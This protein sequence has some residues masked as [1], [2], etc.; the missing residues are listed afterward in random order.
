MNKN[1]CLF[2]I[3]STGL[4]LFGACRRAQGPSLTAVFEG[5]PEQ[6]VYIDYVQAPDFTETYHDTLPLRQGELVWNRE[7]AQ[8]AEV[9]VVLE[10][11]ADAP[12]S[13][14]LCP[15]ESAKLKARWEND[16]W[17]CKLSGSRQLTEQSRLHAL[18]R[19][20]YRDM[21]QLRA[22]INKAMEKGVEYADEQLVDSL[23]ALY[24]EAQGVFSDV[25]M[26]YV[27]AYPEDVRS[28][29]YLMRHPVKDT[30]L[31]YY[32]TL[33]EEVREGFLKEKLE[34]FRLNAERMR[35]LNVNARLT[36]IGA[37]APDFEMTDVDGRSFRLSDY[38][39]KYVVLDFWGT[40]CP[41][42]VKGMPKMKAYHKKY[43]RKVEFIGISNRDKAEKLKDFLQKENIGWRNAQ[44]A[45]AEN[46]DVVLMYGVTGYPTKVL[47]A[48]GLVVKG[49]YLGEVEEF[50][51][52]LDAIK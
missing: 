48:P 26:E 42:C 2:G 49:R 10:R 47:L 21:R 38:K 16:D 44:N 52:E 11:Y 35:E 9:R 18:S 3:L 24:R 36:G 28:A 32:E 43:A 5:E 1:V 34:A 17:Q 6:I 40:W 30:F 25:Y 51:N 45:E 41:W 37:A 23:S 50:Y 8:P 20:A 19:D 13:F 29:I 22:Q 12:V 7:I 15:G 4:L 46:P 27:K 39:D 33:G 14:W 31:A